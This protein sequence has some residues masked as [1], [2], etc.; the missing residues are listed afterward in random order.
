MHE[1]IKLSGIT[2]AEYKKENGIFVGDFI[3]D[4]KRCVSRIDMI[5]NIY[6]IKVFDTKYNS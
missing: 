3:T 2:Q 6:V 4:L 5:P 1:P